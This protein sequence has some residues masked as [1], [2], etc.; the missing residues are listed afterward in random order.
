MTTHANHA[1]LE[2]FRLAIRQFVPTVPKELKTQAKEILGKLHANPQADER[3][4]K[5]AFFDLSVAEY[6]Y[7][8]AYQE[9]T[10]GAA[11]E[12]LKELVLEHV[13]ST[14]RAFLKTH[15]D[16]GVSL[17]ELMK[18]DL[19]DTKLSAAQQYQVE[20]GVRIASSKI[21]DALKGETGEEKAS[22]N[23]LVKKWSD[24]A[25]TIREEIDALEALAEQGNENERGELLEKVAN[26]REGFLVTE[27]DTE[28]ED[29]KKEVEYWKE[30]FAEAA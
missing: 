20:D 27:S 7:R 3:D 18:S 25:T 4:I 13:D 9:L 28:L 23:H 16:A 1:L 10:R 6:P 17:E 2:D 24:H 22:Y 19:F 29:V 11:G 12:K 14:V 8:R 5:Q 30:R 26:F 21:S 15:L